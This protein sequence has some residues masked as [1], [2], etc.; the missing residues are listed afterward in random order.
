MLALDVAGRTRLPTQHIKACFSVLRVHRLEVLAQ[1]LT[2]KPFSNSCSI[3]TCSTRHRF[4][5][6]KFRSTKQCIGAHA[7]ACKSTEIFLPSYANYD[8]QNL[9]NKRD[10]VQEIIVTDEEIANMFPS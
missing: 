1:S 4:T 5:A 10:P 3:S 2:R 7:D 8:F 6:S 9:E